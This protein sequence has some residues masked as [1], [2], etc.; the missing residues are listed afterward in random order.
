MSGVRTEPR[1]PLSNRGGNYPPDVLAWD[2]YQATLA[3]PV[4]VP[5]LLRDLARA[6]GGSEWTPCPA[7]Y[8]YSVGYRL[9]GVET[10]SVQVFE[11]ERD[12]HVQATSRVA[13]PVAEY[14]RRVW[15]DH[16]VSRADVA[17]DVDAPG[18]FER[19]WR[20]VHDQARSGAASGGRKVKTST[21]GDWLDGLD[22][23]TLYTG[24]TSSPLRVVVY[25]KGCEQ[26]GKDPGCGASRDWT[27]VEWRI[28]PDTPA[29]KAWLAKASPAEAT[30]MTPFGAA[31]A[32][33]L[34]TAEV[35]PV[36]SIRRFASQDPGYWMV[37]Q[38]R[39]VVAELLALDPV[40]AMS[41]LAALYEQAEPCTPDERQPDAA[42]RSERAGAAAS[43]AS[44]PAAARSAA[45]GGP[46]S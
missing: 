29:G 35:V 44:G 31:V 39:R 18:A 24:G 32:S 28:R 9:G 19:L 45:P 8:G 17:L 43:E 15:P 20:H 26:L 42:Q 25:E 12:V 11:R 21:A 10:G 41:R 6:V 3:A 40:E 46:P 22:G 4:A 30:G 37:R 27:R 7:L 5:W 14:L 13:V 36:D 34:L 23:R 1:P 16:R 38:Y 2:W 33:S